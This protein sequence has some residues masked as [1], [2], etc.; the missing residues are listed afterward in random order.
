LFLELDIGPGTKE[1]VVE[2]NSTL[3]RKGLVLLPQLLYLNK[4][5]LIFEFSEQNFI[6]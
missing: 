2:F 5:D 6:T 4:V 1:N 3:D